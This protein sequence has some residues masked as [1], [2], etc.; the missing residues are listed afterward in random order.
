MK[1]ALRQGF[2]YMLAAL[3]FAVALQGRGAA[4]VGQYST[5]VDTVSDNKTKLMW[6]RKAPSLTYC[7]SAAEAYCAGLELG[8]YSDWRLPTKCELETIVDR[9][10]QSPSI[11]TT[12]FLDAAPRFFWSSTVSSAGS[13]NRWGVDFSDGSSVYRHWY[14]ATDAQCDRGAPVADTS[15]VRCV[16]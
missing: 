11:D 7:G 12:A 14:L 2:V 15:T 9:R 1:D 16:R 8:G 10:A 6:Q 13:G 5:T 4:P 3:A